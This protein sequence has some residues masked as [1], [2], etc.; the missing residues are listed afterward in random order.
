MTE[1]N[2]LNIIYSNRREA[3]GK[4]KKDQNK[5]EFMYIWL[6]VDNRG[7][8][9][10]GARLWTLGTSSLLANYFYSWYFS[11]FLP[12]AQRWWNSQ[13]CE[14][15][16]MEMVCVCRS[17]CV[18]N[19]CQFTSLMWQ[20]LSSESLCKLHWQYSQDKVKHINVHPSNHEKNRNISQRKMEK[21]L[22]PGNISWFFIFYSLQS[23]A[24]EIWLSL[25]GRSM[26]IIMC[27]ITGLAYW[28]KNPFITYL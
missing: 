11:F 17:P 27:Y 23:F 10:K 24:A 26:N 3:R 8:Q 13:R 7:G 15:P 28:G 16:G 21:M 19:A 2:P 22:P 14:V 4:G 20:D 18:H 9:T 6:T 1:H 12:E 25:N 5:T